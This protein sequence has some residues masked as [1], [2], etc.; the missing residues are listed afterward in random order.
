MTKGDSE[1]AHA[2][3]AGLMQISR[4]ARPRR[5]SLPIAVPMDRFEA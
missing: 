5:D 3:C 4:A 2:P 1:Y